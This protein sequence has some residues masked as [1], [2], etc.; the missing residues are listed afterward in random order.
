MAERQPW[1]PD[2]FWRMRFVTDMR[3]APDGG[4]VAYTVEH[5]DR[6]ANETHSA[7][8]LLDLASG[9]TRQLTSGARRDNSPRWSPDGTQLAFVSTRGEGTAQVWALPMQGGEARQ[10]TRLR[11]GASDPVWSADGS[12]LCVRAEVHP[13]DPEPGAELED[14]EARKRREKDQ[15]DRP[16]VVTRL[17]YRWDGKGY[18]EGRTHLFRVPVE[19]GA[20]EPLTAGDYDNGDAACSADGRYLAF[21]SDRSGE[22][23]A[24]MPNDVWLLDLG[25]GELRRLTD[26][27]ARVSHLAWAPDSQRLAFL[28][29]PEVK[30]GTQ[31]NAALVVAEIET[32]RL[33]NLLEGSDRSATNGLYSD[34]PG[35]SL[36]AP[37]WSADGA[38]LYALSQR[39]GGVDVLRAGLD[40]GPLETVV[41]GA[42]TTIVQV[43]L[44]PTPDGERLLALRSDP[45]HLWDIWSYA[46]PATEPAT[47][48]AT[49][50]EDRPAVAL[51]DVN[52]ALLEE[53]RSVE[54]E[55]FTY[56]SFDGQAIEAWLYR[57]TTV[58]SGAQPA[59]AAPLVLWIH[60]GP[61]GAYG[62][63]FYMQAQMLAGRGYAVLYANPRGSSGY[64]EAFTQAC[65]YDWGGGDYRDLI[66]GVDA[67]LARGGLDGERLAVMGTSYG[68]Y[69][70]NWIVTQSDR[71]KAA[72]TINSVTN[73][74]S[75]F[76]TGDIDSVWAEGDYGWPWEAAAFYHERSPLMHAAQVTTP[77]R[78][79]AAEQDYRCP[80]AQSEEWFTWL[81][82]L[83]RAP[84]DFVR[85]PGASHGVFASPRQRVRRMELV[86]EWIE[87]WAPIAAGTAN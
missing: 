59:Q 68:G 47:G 15:A 49:G 3:V 39:G 16:R 55:R 25:S 50:P 22:R 48:S 5:N 71:F 70:A 82:K 21:V 62:Q 83:G 33:V 67:A 27:H 51:P 11:H 19:D 40:G 29:E 60:G 78:I 8:W 18:F 46:L 45:T 61:H 35:P 7:I 4:R 28:A 85:L 58:A 37:V 43:A 13:D 54:P 41:D 66:A 20:V 64:G 53:R 52:A 26:G 69:M 1:T 10:L 24:N 80:I 87:R 42:S 76:G 57:P 31:Y 63:L 17:Q 6:E 74:Y 12:W 75:S 65:D 72:V 79:I 36:S 38:S 86:F 34:T 2:D 44:A 81:K 30:R 84:V 32:G 14:E 23:D 9:A 56:E 73:L 77:I